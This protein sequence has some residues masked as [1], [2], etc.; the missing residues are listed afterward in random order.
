MQ[1]VAAQTQLVRCAAG[2]TNAKSMGCS[3][4]ALAP[5]LTVEAIQR[6][7]REYWEMG[8][9][10]QARWRL[11][12]VRSVG[13]ESNIG[14]RFQVEGHA[15]CLRCWATLLGFS[16]QTAYA[17]LK[18]AKTGAYT[19][20]HGNSHRAA[21]APLTDSVAAWID[22]YVD[23]LCDK[24]PD[25]GHYNVPAGITRVDMYNE[26]VADQ[27]SMST[28]AASKSTF[29]KT[30]AARFPTLRT[31]TVSRFTKCDQVWRSIPLFACL[32]ATAFV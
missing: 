9:R 13:R 12:V 23:G 6:A 2:L 18:A 31:P 19:L 11:S 8:Q 20:E 5:T 10:D 27:Q 21:N 17:S 28:C 29:M 22:L 16:T 25:S 30:I 26:Y 1:R 3:C 15:V 32:D 14:A 4:V 7:R 24:M